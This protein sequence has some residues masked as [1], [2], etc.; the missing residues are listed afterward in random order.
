MLV[1]RL[2]HEG[3]H[4]VSFPP[5]FREEKAG[6]S[7]PAFFIAKSVQLPPSATLPHAYRSAERCRIFSLTPAANSAG[8]NPLCCFPSRTRR[9]TL[10][11]FI[12]SS[13]TT[14]M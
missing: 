3:A 6:K 1:G 2:R 4:L 13:P 9:A 5:F 11:A 7:M 12:S 14:S 8:S 10:P